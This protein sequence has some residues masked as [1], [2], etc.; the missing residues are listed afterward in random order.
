MDLFGNV[1]IS[2]NENNRD[3]LLFELYYFPN[4]V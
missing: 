1:L 4:P 2:F 3:V